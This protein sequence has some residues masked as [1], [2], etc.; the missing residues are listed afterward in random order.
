VAYLDLKPYLKSEDIS[1]DLVRLILVTH[2][3]MP[4]WAGAGP[5]GRTCR[6][7]VFWQSNWSWRKGEPAPARCAKFEILQ[8]RQGFKIPHTAYACRHFELNDQPQP[9]RR[10]PPS[11]FGA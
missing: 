4:D 9:I 5:M 7:C 11:V 1:E 8:H 3:G 10:P 6:E 2:K